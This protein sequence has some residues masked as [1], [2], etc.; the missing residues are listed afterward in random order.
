[1]ASVATIRIGLLIE[2]TLISREPRPRKKRPNALDSRSKW[3]L[4]GNFERVALPLELGRGATPK[5]MT[6]RANRVTI[7][8]GSATRPPP[9]GHGHRPSRIRRP[10]LF[11]ALRAPKI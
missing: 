3:G 1:M 6:P 9:D 2:Q 10:S 11:A 4:F 5:A 8:K 7:K